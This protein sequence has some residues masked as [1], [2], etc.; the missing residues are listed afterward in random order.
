MNTQWSTMFSPLVD[1]YDGRKMSD[2]YSDDSPQ[3]KTSTPRF[4]FPPLS[5]LLESAPFF[6]SGRS[7]TVRNRPGD[8]GTR[9]RVILFSEEW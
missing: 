7:G 2:G 5:G 8:G 4:D 6:W 1:Q 3:K 9:V